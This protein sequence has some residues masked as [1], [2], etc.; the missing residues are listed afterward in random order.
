M[1]RFR[2]L[3]VGL[4]GAGLGLSLI[5]HSPLGVPAAYAEDSDKLRPEVGKPLQKAQEFVK[6]HKLPEAA[7]QV[8]EADNAKNKTAYESFVI[9]QVRGS[10]AQASG[11][12]AAAAKSYEAQI[13][14]G[15]V[16][17]AEVRLSETR[18]RRHK[19]TNGFN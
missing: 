13:A 9:E 3:S 5:P 15:R 4:I 19:R 12:Y 14:S 8:R 6:Q 11:A 17:G 10:I 16:S 18:A 2:L 1:T 7:A